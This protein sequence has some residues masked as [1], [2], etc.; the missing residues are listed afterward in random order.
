M[1]GNV[2]S[3]WPPAHGVPLFYLEKKEASPSPFSPGWGT[4]THILLLFH[5]IPTRDG[6][7][8]SLL[9]DPTDSA[10]TTLDDSLWPL[11]VVR[12]GD[13]TERALEAYLAAREAYLARAQ[14]HVVIIDTR[15]VHLPPPRVRQRYIDWL[16]KHERALRQWTLGSAYIIGSPAVRVMMSLI[17]HL[18]PMTTP[19]LVTET[20][21]PSAA[22][23]AERLQEAGHAQMATRVRAHYALAA[24]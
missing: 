11:L 4:A 21:P 24:S 18:A 20:L 2:G 22:W 17:R 16:T 23:A 13:A 1:T 14:P 6:M 8:P 15:A 5:P 10:P 7:P 9:P 3:T 12:F 19:F